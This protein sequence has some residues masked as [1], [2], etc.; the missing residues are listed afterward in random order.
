MSKWVPDSRKFLTSNEMDRLKETVRQKSL[1]SKV[2]EV[3]NCFVRLALET[4]LRVSEMTNLK[5]KDVF[6]NGNSFLRVQHGKGNKARN[7][8]LPS[9]LRDYLRAYIKERGL[10]PE[11]YLLISSHNKPFSRFGLSYMWNTCCRMADI[12]PRGVHS[13]RHSYA[14]FLQ[15][16]THDLKLVQ[17]QLGHSNVS[18]TSVYLHLTNEEISKKLDSV[19]S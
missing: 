7:V 16:K 10:Q 11:D 2:Y 15:Q 5:V 13:S 4:G 14:S 12:V 19:F 9:S 17:A 8:L 1:T 3:A 6:F 18:I